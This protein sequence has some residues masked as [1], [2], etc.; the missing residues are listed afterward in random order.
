VLE[1]VALD[2]NVFALLRLLEWQEKF[3]FKSAQPAPLICG[4]S[5]SDCGSMQENADGANRGADHPV[6]RGDERYL[7]GGLTRRSKRRTGKMSSGEISASSAYTSA[8]GLLA[9][10]TEP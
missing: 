5:V 4:V 1:R 8:F 9:R 10:D 6:A 2:A 7:Y 3:R